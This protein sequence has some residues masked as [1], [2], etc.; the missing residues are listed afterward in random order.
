M[1]EEPIAAAKTTMRKSVAM[2]VSTASLKELSCVARWRGLHCWRWRHTADYRHP[3][4][5]K[6]AASG[7][8]LHCLHSLTS[9]EWKVPTTFSNTASSQHVVVLA[10]AWQYSRLGS[11]QP[12]VVPWRRHTTVSC[13]SFVSASPE[14]HFFW[15]S[16]T[17][18][19]RRF[20]I[21]L[22]RHLAQDAT[23]LVLASL[24]Q[25]CCV[26]PWIKG[27]R[28]WTTVGDVLSKLHPYPELIR[29]PRWSDWCIDRDPRTPTRKSRTSSQHSVCCKLSLQQHRNP[30]VDRLNK[31]S[32][33]PVVYATPPAG[34]AFQ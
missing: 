19:P 5:F 13:E 32:R 31:P 23:L 8:W 34:C 3:C 14:N 26:T 15:F 33:L 7:C 2:S 9:V 18:M 11:R 17:H 28:N 24:L 10:N 21:F 6:R 29:T 16:E 4:V 30:Q 25:K 22:R 20:S 27:A 1:V 12:G